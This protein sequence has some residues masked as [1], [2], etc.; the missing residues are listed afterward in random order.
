MIGRLISA[1]P[2]AQKSKLRGWYQNQKLALVRRFR[3]YDAAALKIRLR[4]M[5][6]RSGDTLM[7]HTAFGRQLGFQGPPSALIEAYQEAVGPSGNLL[8]VSMPYFSS[9]SEYLKSLK[10]FDVR[11]TPS[12][13]GLISE[14]FRRMPGVVRSLHPT[15]PVLALGPKAEWIVSGHEDCLFPCGPGSPFGKL[16]ELQGK[17]L[18]HGVTEFHFTFHHY[19]EDMV[20]DDLPFPLYESEPYRV[21]VVDAL[22]GSR[23]MVTYA[24]TREAISRRRVH[25]LFDELARRG[26]LIRSRIGNT[27]I[28]VM[29]TADTVETTRD[30]ARK[31]I[32]FYAMP[33]EP[34]RGFLRRIKSDI[35]EAAIRRSLPP[36]GRAELKRDHQGLREEDPGIGKT[37]EGAIGWIGRAQDFSTSKDGGVARVYHL[38]KGWSS[39]YPETTGYIIPTFLEHAKHTGSADSRLRAGRMAQW[40]RSIQLPGGGFQGGRIDSTPVTPVVFNTGQI[41]MGLAAAENAFGGYGESLRRAADWLVGIQDPDG[42]WRRYSSPFAGGGVKTYDTHTA[43]GL[44]EAA[45]IEPDRGYAEAALANI[46][47][48]LSYQSGNGWFAKCCLSNAAIPLAHTLGYALRGV[49][50]AYRFTQDS[51]YLDA[52]RKTADALLGKLRSDG[53]LP[54]R[55]LPD[56]SAAATWACLTG[57]AQI[58]ICWFML[59]RITGDKRYLDAAVLANGFVRRT[60]SF[61]VPP[62][63]AGGVKGSFPLDGAYSRYEYPNWAAK[64]LIDSLLLESELAGPSSG[65]TAGPSSGVTAGPSSG[66]TAGPS[67]GVTAGRSP[68]A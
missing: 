31:G 4:E 65:V 2:P 32:Y 13:M 25:V 24:F 11:T 35:D 66:V 23:T 48:A 26:Q 18:F 42:C 27:G 29:A 58:A 63:M 44:L 56:W 34:D 57:S 12:K 1:L 36:A 40:L 45:R 52:S 62:G 6:I 14:M 41:L 9:T 53:F 30:L 19:L 17:V 10:E 3:S 28:V 67:S 43:W 7:I 68:G 46:D 50:E 55:F 22:G 15:H 64:F 60:V 5:G 20:K 54:G 16:A 37:M 33:G 21:K 39:S 51:K 38:F 47:W 8:M 61:D 59:F 49:L